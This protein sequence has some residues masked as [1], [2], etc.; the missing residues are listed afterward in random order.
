MGGAIQV[1]SLHTGFD[2]LRR[3][4]ISFFIRQIASFSLK[5]IIQ[6]TSTEYLCYARLCIELLDK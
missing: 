1:F 3:V 5:L 6:Q 2:Q 4:Q